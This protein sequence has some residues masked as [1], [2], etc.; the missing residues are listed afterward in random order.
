MPHFGSLLTILN[1]AVLAKSPKARTVPSSLTEA[2]T[3][4][5]P[6]PPLP[7][8]LCLTQ[9]THPILGRVC[10]DFNFNLPFSG[11]L[12]EEGHM[13]KLP[14]RTKG[15]PNF[16]FLFGVGKEFCFLRGGLEFF[17]DLKLFLSNKDSKGFGF[18]FIC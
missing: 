17:D 14:P 10:V 1:C 4:Y 6:C 16:V 11:S 5:C 9:F 15:N 13:A 12:L 8:K 18:V 3:M 7:A 2:R